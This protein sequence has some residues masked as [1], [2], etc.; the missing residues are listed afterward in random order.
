MDCPCIS[1]II[2]VY[3]VEDYLDRCLQSVL[4][5]TYSELEV[6]CVND[7]STDSS[8]MILKK[9]QE[10][11][12]RVIVVSHEN[13]GLPEARNSG[14]EVMTGDYIAFIDADDWVHP[15]YF[16]ALLDC[17]EETGADMVVSGVRRF[18]ADEVVD[19]DPNVE[20][21][22][23][24]L[25]GEAF[26]NNFYA[27][28]VI[29]GRLLRRRDTKHLR[30][31]P[32]VDAN[33]DNLYNLKLIASW[34]QPNVYEVDA[35]LYYYLNRPKSL[36]KLRTYEEMLQIADWYE[37]YE[38]DPYHKKNGEWGRFLL[39]NSISKTMY[40][41]DEAYAHKD[42]EVI[43]RSNRLLRSMMADLLRDKTVRPHDKI[44][45]PL[46]ILFPHLYRCY[47]VF[48][49]RGLLKKIV[50]K[51]EHLIISAAGFD[52]LLRETPPADRRCVQRKAPV[53]RA[54][55]GK[56]ARRS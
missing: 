27:R 26:Y 53:R 28:Y 46:K 12:P 51:A 1:V 35:P 14:L 21:R 31:P 52:P 39:L 55:R 29:W 33:Q 30:F 43:R 32:E 16:R 41:R 9:W 49:V 37:K 3:N 6:I 11:D 50:L 24:K 36:S 7:G 56:N 38:R 13:R 19:V 44:V 20:L 47:T 2:P 22:R 40:C 15:Q 8:P 45:L 42:R 4:T 10:Q 23:R 18:S 25:T 48:N 34:K 5:N 54:R 17:M